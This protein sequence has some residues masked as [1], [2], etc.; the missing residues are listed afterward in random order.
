MNIVVIGGGAAGMTAAITAAGTDKNNKITIIEHGERVGKKILSTGNGKCNLTNLNMSPH[1]F[2]CDDMRFVKEVLSQFDE[3]ST[4]DFFTNLGVMFK[5]RDGY[6][7]P[8][9]GQAATILD[10]LRNAVDSLGIKTLNTENV[11]DIKPLNPGFE[12]VLNDRKIMA[13]KLI[14]ATGSSASNLKEADDS[15]YKLVKRLGYRIYKPLPALTGLKSDNKLCKGMAGVRCDGRVSLY[16]DGVLTAT[17]T[18]E[19]QL[20]EYGISGI[21]VFQVSRYAARALYEG[22]KVKAFVDFMP[23][24][25]REEIVK[26]FYDKIKNWPGKSMENQ[27]YGILNK[28]IADAVIKAC[29]FESVRNKPLCRD[30][31]LI[32]IDKIKEFEFNIK[33]TSELEKAQICTGGVLINQIDARTME[34]KKHKGLYFAG[35]I[36]DVDGICG[37]YNLQWAWSTG[38]IAGRNSVC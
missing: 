26:S 22:K 20:A 24:F 18:G 8:Y 21:P 32:I 29:G 13:D 30:K 11:T 31:A 37:G 19:I 3:K 7:Y 28:K 35:E 4:L 38:Y 5:I 2:R 17:D 25:S 33:G 10:A 16:V 9:S 27:L 1:C 34:S 6:V 23:A 36:L 14:I 15:G 12:I